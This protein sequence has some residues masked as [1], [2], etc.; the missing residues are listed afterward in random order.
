MSVLWYDNYI[1]QIANLLVIPSTDA[2]FQVMTPGMI[3]YAEN[4]LYREL[5]LVAASVTDYGQMTAN[6]RDITFPTNFGDYVVVDN[7]NVLYPVGTTSSNG[8]RSPLVATTPDVIDAI[9]PSNTGDTGVPR[10]WAIIDSSHAIVGPS[11]AAAYAFE[12]RGQQVPTPLSSANSST[13]LTSLFP[14][15]MVAASMVFASGYQ[16]DFSAQGD[17]PAQG[18]SW[19]TQ[20]QILIKSAATQEARKQYQAQGWTANSD[21]PSASPPRV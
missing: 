10:F 9:W 19:E 15:L 7:F 11:P 12:I 13:P 14:D 16:R 20:Y 1:T 3:S 18:N 4:R 8:T 6:S 5:D 2:N 17:N 21:S